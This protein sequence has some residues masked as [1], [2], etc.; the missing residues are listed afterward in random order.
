MGVSFMRYIY[1]NSVEVVNALAFEG[2]TLGQ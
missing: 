1:R 2:K